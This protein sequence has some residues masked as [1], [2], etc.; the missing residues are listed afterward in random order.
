[1]YTAVRSPSARMLKMAVL[2]TLDP[3]I[4]TSQK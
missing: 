4:D 2:V 3:T 1:L